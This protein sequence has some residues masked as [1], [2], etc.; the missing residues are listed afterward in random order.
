MHENAQ[1]IGKYPNENGVSKDTSSRMIMGEEVIETLT[2]PIQ[3]DE[4]M[5]SE[6][7]NRYVDDIFNKLPNRK[8]FENYL[9]GIEA[10]RVKAKK[11]KQKQKTSKASRKANRRK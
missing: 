11:K 6:Q 1:Q 5:T 10:D 4:Q 8:S 9:A 7:I 3:T 2:G